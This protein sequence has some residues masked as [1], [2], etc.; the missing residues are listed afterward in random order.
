VVRLFVDGCQTGS[1]AA[2]LLIEEENVA[3][4]NYTMFGLDANGSKFFDGELAEFLAYSE[5][6]PNMSVDQV[7]SPGSLHRNMRACPR[8]PQFSSIQFTVLMLDEGWLCKH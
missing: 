3:D 6:I 2:E 7:M 5:P 8:H 1:P 4:I